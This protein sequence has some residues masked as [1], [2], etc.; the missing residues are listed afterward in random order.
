MAKKCGLLYDK[1]T[2]FAEIVKE[3][4]KFVSFNSF[5][6]TVVITRRYLCSVKDQIFD[7][8][9]NASSF[10]CQPPMNSQ[11]IIRPIANKNT[12]PY[13]YIELEGPCISTNQQRLLE[14]IA[15]QAKRLSKQN[16]KNE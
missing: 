14:S 1:F 15:V 8:L 10:N 7:G 2:P 11:A 13:L 4:S 3:G 6:E 12:I 5:T 9:I 16:V